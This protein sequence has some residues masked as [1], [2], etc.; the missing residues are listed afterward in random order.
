[1][2]RIFKKR[3]VK[4]MQITVDETNLKIV[5]GKLIIDITA[6]IE[7]ALQVNKVK[8]STLKPGEHFMIGDKEFMVLEQKCNSTRIIA[9][10]F[11]L[12]MKFGE[13][14]D[15]RE[16][17]IRKK[18]NGD[19]LKEIENYVDSIRILSFDRDL[20]SL[21][22]LDDFDTCIDRISLLSADEYRKYHKILSVNKEYPDW[23]YLI[24]SYSTPSN[25]YATCVCSVNYNGALSWR[26]CDYYN[27]VRPFLILDSSILV[28]QVR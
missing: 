4:S 10:D 2:F 20:T 21:D 15:W 16:S 9:A 14:C 25:D 17:D 5:D 22:G 7:K 8:L 23:W 13:N 3:K 11:H 26:G 27:S 18:L 12:K 19:Y 1:M 6:D 28:N 24:T